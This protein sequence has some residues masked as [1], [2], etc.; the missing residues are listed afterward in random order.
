MKKIILFFLVFSFVI[1]SF[2]VFW[3]R[4]SIQNK[5]LPDHSSRVINFVVLSDMGEYDESIKR[6]IVDHLGNLAKKNQID[7][8]A[9][10]GDPIHGD[11]VESITDKK[12]EVEFENVY[13]A[14]SLHKMPFY[15]VSGNHEYHGN[16]QAIL[17]YSAISE[18]WNAPAR[19]FFFEQPVDKQ[20]KALFVFIDT[21]PLIDEYRN[22][23]SDAGE[24]CIERQ[25]FW[26][27]STLVASN[28]R[29]KIVIGHHP[30]Y[31]KT[32]KIEKQQTDLQERVGK[33][34]EN[35]SVD[36]Y[37]SGHVHNFQYIKLENKITNYIVNSSASDSREVAPIEGTI[38]CKSDPGYTLFTV[39]ADSV[40]FSFINH[41]GTTIYQNVFRK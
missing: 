32:E 19:Y 5:Q 2:L 10:A 21:T 7:F 12:W 9:V 35:R 13:T 41:I 24:Q 36:F 14:Y 3:N 27:D 26:L 28:S 40:Q 4:V 18:R 25:L 16:V 20:Q 6:K 37:I 1:F 23:Y 11:G 30:V 31:A 38:F 8:V 29:W 15:V 39:S 34:L 22:K 17:D 33:I